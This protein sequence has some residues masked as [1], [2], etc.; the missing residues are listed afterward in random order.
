MKLRHILPALIICIPTLIRAQEWTRIIEDPY[1]NYHE[2]LKAFTSWREPILAELDTRRAGAE[3]PERI[4]LKNATRRFKA[5][6]KVYQ[7]SI[8]A[9]GDPLTAEKLQ[10]RERDFHGPFRQKSAQQGGW[11]NYGPGEAEYLTGLGVVCSIASSPVMPERIYIGTW[12]SGIWR[13]DDNGDSWEPIL[14]SLARYTTASIAV[15]P[16]NSDVV[17]VAAWPGLL[18]STDA[19]GHWEL[20][21]VGDLPVENPSNKI[22]ID[23]SDPQRIWISGSAGMVRS[24]DAGASWT[25][26]ND[27][28]IRDLELKSGDPQTMFAY[29]P[30]QPSGFR[31]VLRSTDGGLNFDT[32]AT[33]AGNNTNG[34]AGLAVTAADPERL[35]VYLPGAAIFNGAPGQI[36]RSLDGGDSFELMPTSG[37][38]RGFYYPNVIAASD[39]DPDVVLAGDIYLSS[40]TDGGTTWAGTH[41]GNH[42][43][44][45]YMHVDHRAV[46]FMNGVA[47]SCNDGGIYSSADGGASWTDRTGTMAIGHVTD[48]DRWIGDTVSFAMGMD[49]NGC[50]FKGE[51]PW[52]M[53]FGG[54]GY[55]VA[56]DPD[57]P[58][59]V[60][61][62]NEDGNTR[63]TFD[64]GLSS[65]FVSGITETAY[66]FRPD[67]PCVFNTQRPHTVYALRDNVFRS[68]DRGVTW[69]QLSDFATNEG[70]G[71]LVVHPADSNVMYTGFWRS[72][73]NG[74]SWSPIGDPEIPIWPFGAIAVDQDDPARAWACSLGGQIRVYY[75]N[76]TGATWTLTP[77]YDLPSS[78]GRSLIHIDNG[79]DAL[80]LVTDAGVYFKDDQVS[81]WQP[82]SGNL[83]FCTLYDIMHHPMDNKLS[84]SVYGR[85]IW[86]ADLFDTTQAPVAD[87]LAE[88]TVVC[89]GQSVTFHDNSLNNGLGYDPQ[90]LW[91]FPGGVPSTSADAD[92]VVTYPSAGVFSVSLSITNANGEDSIMYAAL[93]T[94]E[95]PIAQLPLNEG[96]EEEQFPPSGWS[97]EDPNG[98]ELWYHWSFPG[99]VFGGYGDSPSSARYNT[100]PSGQVLDALLTPTYELGSPQEWALLYDRAYRYHPDTARWDSLRVFFTTDCDDTRNTLFII[101]GGDLAT[102]PASIYSLIPDSSTW[103]TDTVPLGVVPAFEPVRFGFEVPTAGSVGLYLDNVRLEL[104]QPM[105]LPEP[106]AHDLSIAPNPANNQ[107]TVRFGI[108]TEGQLMVEDASGRL[109]RSVPVR[110]DQVTL[111]THAL[112]SG[113][114][115]FR[116]QG[117]DRSVRC[118]IAH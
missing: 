12:F 62:T 13:S 36:A 98:S 73:D 5:W 75:S 111:E 70:T 89:P 22:T 83:P 46:A 79:H 87:L 67:K 14:D 84:L 86:M 101:G 110:G 8:D 41:S 34:I 66:G 10:R 59:H 42:E 55:N 19:G 21:D 97:N 2:A 43:D 7:G 50:S 117:T 106:T 57:D 69:S 116:L 113:V 104:L 1:V 115:V 96:F 3:D 68:F 99:Y 33:F 11:A 54:D 25:M 27:A 18:R 102:S 88:D 81:N 28:H 108:P 82:F 30:G 38:L 16:T 94:V 52:R 45:D 20:L 23:P 24:E 95:E 6:A 35:Y 105:G 4:A 39:T 29:G 92:P 109:V 80:Y 118:I 60:F 100:L 40:S 44:T 17:Y 103:A 32:V 26:I 72:T 77:S 78:T 76:D 37:T 56:I 9:H 51:G 114:Y 107:L 49:H 71:V 74:D 31:N 15:D 58:L 65:V 112:R 48:H 63:Q 93:I 61:G 47:W 85:G 90:Y 91:S 53:F 64:G